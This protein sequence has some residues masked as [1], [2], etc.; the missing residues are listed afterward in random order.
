MLKERIIDH[1]NDR[2]KETVTDPESSEVVHAQEEPLS[3]H[4]GHG[5]DK[6]RS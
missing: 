6:K 4:R 1:A 3:E 5:S 2:Y